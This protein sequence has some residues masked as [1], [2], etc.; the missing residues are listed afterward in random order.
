VRVC[1][2][3]AAICAKPFIGYVRVI[4]PAKNVLVADVFGTGILH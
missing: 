1:D 2:S 3:V 4:V